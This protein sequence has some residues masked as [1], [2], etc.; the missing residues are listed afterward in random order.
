MGK[1]SKRSLWVFTPPEGEVYLICSDRDLEELV[2]EVYG[3]EP[4]VNLS[5]LINVA[6]TRLPYVRF[7]EENAKFGDRWGWRIIAYGRTDTPDEGKSAQWIARKRRQAYLFTLAG[8]ANLTLKLEYPDGECPLLGAT[9][10]IDP[11]S[12]TAS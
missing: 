2:S 8:L 6:H 10:F 7:L 12:S 3:F 11:P 4:G 5:D 1:A 9:I